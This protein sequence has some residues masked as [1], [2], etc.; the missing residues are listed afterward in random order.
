MNCKEALMHDW[1]K[2][3]YPDL[4]KKRIEVCEKKSF[5]F[6]VFTSFGCEF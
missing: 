4:V 6:E 1:I 5:E 2:I 3:Y